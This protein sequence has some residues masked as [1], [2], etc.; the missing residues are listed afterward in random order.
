M[1]EATRPIGTGDTLIV[2]DLN[3]QLGVRIVNVS[4]LTGD[5]GHSIVELGQGQTRCGRNEIPVVIGVSIHVE[6]N[7]GAIHTRSKCGGRDARIVHL[8]L[9]GIDVTVT[10]NWPWRMRHIQWED[11]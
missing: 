8:P 10:P 6:K 3:G 4:H 5:L 7:N 2:D 11:R 9:L 1:L